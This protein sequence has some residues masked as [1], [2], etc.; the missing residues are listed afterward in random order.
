MSTAWSEIITASMTVID[1]ERLNELLTVSPAQF[2]RRMSD[3]VK[4]ALPALK[5]PPELLSTL[6]AGMDL[7]EY[8][9]SVWTSTVA[10]TSA[11]T[12]V[13]TGM[14]G[15]DLC[16]VII[17]S[18]DPAGGVLYDAY[19]DAV[20]NSE[21]GVVTF[22]IQPDIGIDYMMDFYKDGEFPT[23]T[24]SQM[25]LFALAVAVLWDRRFERTWLNLTV[26]IH[27]STFDVVNESN[28]LEKSSQRLVRNVQDFNDKLKAYE[29]MCAYLTTTSKS[30]SILLA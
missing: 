19:P 26:K 24:E 15:Y 5:R 3:Y 14:I 23:L 2:Y 1:D 22:P 18:G 13:A 10:S 8:S 17:R 29:Q 21:T 16:S 7:P 12:D 20:Y 9:D 30:S 27:D 11:S 25:E 6:Q 28:Y 4:M